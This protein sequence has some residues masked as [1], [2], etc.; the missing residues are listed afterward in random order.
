[1]AGAQQGVTIEYDIS[2]AETFAFAGGLF[3]V[4]L[5]LGPGIPDGSPRASMPPGWNRY[6]RAAGESGLCPAA[7][8]ARRVRTR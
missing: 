7:R 3:N 2:G 1:M 4:P 5:G 8:T 6:S